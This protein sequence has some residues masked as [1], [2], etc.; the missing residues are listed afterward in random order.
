MNPLI[1]AICAV[2]VLSQ[3]VSGKVWA[4]APRQANLPPSQTRPQDS[5]QAALKAG[6]PQRALEIADTAL[7]TFPNDAQLRF[8]RAV[9]LNLLGRLPEAEAAFAELTVEYPELPEPYNNLAVVR[10]AQGKLDLARVALEDAIRAVPDYPVAH[11]NLGDIHAQL[12][13]RS[14]LNAQ[15]LDPGSKTIPS[16]LK[17]VSQVAA[18]PATAPLPHD[19]QTLLLPHNPLPRPRLR[20]PRPRPLPRACPPRK[21]SKAKQS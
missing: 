10:A 4:Q 7:K 21:A 8:I 5:A 16:K 13:A 18:Q 3:L 9:S 1:A 19:P 12:A 14:Y 11:E 17:L 6:N 15:R 2:L 20:N